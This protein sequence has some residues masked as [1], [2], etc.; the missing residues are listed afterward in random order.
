MITLY[1]ENN[2]TYIEGAS[3]AI[4]DVIDQVIR[5]PSNLVVDSTVQLINEMRTWDGWVRLLNRPKT[6]LPWFL[7]GLIGYVYNILT[8]HSIPKRGG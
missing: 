1:V 8:Q 5:Y 7:T 3:S 6:M 2:R 4:L